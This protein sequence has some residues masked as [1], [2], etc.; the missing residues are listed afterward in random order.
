MFSSF[1]SSFNRIYLRHSWNGVASGSI[2]WAE[3]RFT[4]SESMV[5]QGAVGFHS[6][7]VLY[8][9]TTSFFCSKRSLDQFL[10]LTNNR[11][12]EIAINALI[13]WAICIVSPSEQS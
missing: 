1:Q 12:S 4:V 5:L 10:V 9:M 8:V 3:F 6:Q 7:F 2:S 13:L 11:G